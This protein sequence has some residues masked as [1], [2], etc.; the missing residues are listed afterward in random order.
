MRSARAIAGVGCHASWPQRE[1]KPARYG[2]RNV[3]AGRRYPSSKLCSCCGDRNRAL[4]LAKRA[5]TYVNCGAPR[6]RRECGAHLQ[7]LAAGALAARTALPLPLAWRRRR[8]AGRLGAG[9]RRCAPV[10]TFSI[11]VGHRWSSSGACRALPTH[12]RTPTVSVHRCAK[13]Y[14][15]PGKR[16][17]AYAT[18]TAERSTRAHDSDHDCV[19]LG[20]D[21]A[22]WRNPRA[23]G[24]ARSRIP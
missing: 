13:G 24:P 5:L 14:A 19:S 11:A 15:A 23:L 7:W 18:V 9:R 8:P 12:G 4:A 20:Q 16:T 21:R 6:S 3:L 22:R 17:P 2:T 1:Y 10:R